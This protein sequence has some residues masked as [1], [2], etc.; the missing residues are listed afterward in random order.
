MG[1]HSWLVK[2]GKPNDHEGGLEHTGSCE[3]FNSF[4][5]V[6]QSCMTRGHDTIPPHALSNHS[7]GF[8][9]LDFHG[10]PNSKINSIFEAGNNP[11]SLYNIGVDRMNDIPSVH[12]LWASQE[13][14]C[15]GLAHGQR[16]RWGPEE[17]ADWNWEVGKGAVGLCSKD[18][19]CLRM[20]KV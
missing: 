4:K 20:L 2:H 18:L 15:P 17:S 12:Q 3:I 14:S 19:G 1:P 7:W 10:K 13:A 16:G 6:M 11:H 9:I 5:K 8:I